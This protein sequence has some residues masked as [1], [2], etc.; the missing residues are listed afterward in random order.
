[1]QTIILI[2]FYTFIVLRL[3]TVVLSASVVFPCL[4]NTGSGDDH[5]PDP[6]NYQDKTRGGYFERSLCRR[7][8]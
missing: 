6:F 8:L 5:L 4:D 2:T 1:M 3:G 7:I